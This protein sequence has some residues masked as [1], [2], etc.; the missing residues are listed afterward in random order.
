MNGSKFPEAFEYQIVQ[1]S[2]SQTNHEMSQ[3]SEYWTSIQMLFENQSSFGPELK[4][5]QKVQ[6]WD[7]PTSRVT[8]QSI[9]LSVTKKSLDFRLIL[10]SGIRYSDDYTVVSTSI[11]FQ[12]SGVFDSTL[13][14]IIFTKKTQSVGNV[15]LLF[16]STLSEMIL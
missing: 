5:F 13:F 7:G 4:M 14:K 1:Y 12:G 3:M 11:V 15:K 9:Y 16:C 6:F 2:I 10:N 8:R